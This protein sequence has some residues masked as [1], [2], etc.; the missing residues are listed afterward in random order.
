MRNNLPP[1]S[2][3]WA[4]D[5]EQRVNQLDRQA[6][7]ADQDAKNAIEML[8]LRVTQIIH[9]Q[10]DINSAVTAVQSAQETLTTQQAEIT[11]T[12]TRLAQTTQTVITPRSRPLTAGNSNSTQT[13]STMTKPEWANYSI[14]TAGGSYPTLVGS[15]ASP[16]DFV[17]T[18]L[19]AWT[20]TTLPTWMT[21]PLGDISYSGDGFYTSSGSTIL[22]M[23]STNELYIMEK[24]SW[25]LV[26]A[27]TLNYNAFASIVWSA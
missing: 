19:Y 15:G 13:V 21:N 9:Q 12:N 2:Q 5:I 16:E 18:E 14:V 8:N 23:R 6:R 27:K 17:T 3:P 4:R 26:S 10:A 24:V 1:E 20:S 22:D 7:R 25:S 11:S